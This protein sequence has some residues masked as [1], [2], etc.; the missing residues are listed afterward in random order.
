MSFRPKAILPAVESLWNT[1]NLSSFQK[2]IDLMT[3]MFRRIN[4]GMTV[5]P[6][7]SVHNESLMAVVRAEMLLL[8][9]F[10]VRKIK[11][12]PIHA[13]DRTD[14]RPAYAHKCHEKWGVGPSSRRIF[15]IN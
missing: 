14:S 5:G 13:L 4:G 6:R 11:R 15:M 7:L 9:K 1:L 2:K 8:Q 12:L 10:P 3:C